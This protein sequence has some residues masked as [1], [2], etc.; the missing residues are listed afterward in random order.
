MKVVGDS[1][2]E[3][4][5]KCRVSCMRREGWGVERERGERE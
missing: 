2:G 5:T 4:V 1:L 3:G